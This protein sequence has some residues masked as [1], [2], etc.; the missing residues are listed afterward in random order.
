LDKLVGSG[1][2]TEEEADRL[3]GGDRGVIDDT[4][5]GIRVRHA[6]AQLDAAITAREISR[7]E[8]DRFLERIWAGEHSPQL[9]AELARILGAGRGATDR[10]G[11]NERWSA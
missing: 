11:A 9:R 10:P 2:I 8:A 5:V 4:V 6:R 1:R 3:R 7:E